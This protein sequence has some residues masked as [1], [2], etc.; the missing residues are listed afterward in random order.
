MAG[1]RDLIQHM[2]QGN[3]NV[4]G[5]ETSWG[6]CITETFTPINYNIPLLHSLCVKWRNVGHALD[7]TADTA[8]E[9]IGNHQR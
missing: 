4:L 9:G 8:G 1:R 5:I 7:C 2:E 6:M 3:A